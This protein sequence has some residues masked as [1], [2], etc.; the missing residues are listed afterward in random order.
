M[1][2]EGVTDALDYVGT[3]SS[4]FISDLVNQFSGRDLTK[5]DLTEINN[6][7]D[8]VK[9]LMQTLKYWLTTVRDE[10]LSAARNMS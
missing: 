8:Q 4:T 5:E 1:A 7:G 9:M 6:I 2:P 3:I 10:Q